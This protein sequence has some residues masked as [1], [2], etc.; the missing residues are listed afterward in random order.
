MS[1]PTIILVYKDEVI[2]NHYR[3][4]LN[5][6]IGPEYKVG[7]K[8]VDLFTSDRYLPWFADAMTNCDNWIIIRP[9]EQLPYGKKEFI[10]DHE[11]EHIMDPFEDSEYVIS[12]RALNPSRQY[13]RDRIKLIS[14]N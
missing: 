2:E 14:R 12:R 13:M 8:Y 4:R 9:D 7:D 3:S 5:E 10:L 6:R 11:K 1:Y